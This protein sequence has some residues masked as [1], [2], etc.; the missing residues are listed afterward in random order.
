MSEPSKLTKP[1]I[2]LLLGSLLMGI[3]FDYL[4]YHK[5]VG[6]S[7]PIFWIVFS[8]FFYLIFRDKLKIEKKFE[9]FLI[10]P[11]LL[12]ILTFFFYS[13]KD[14]YV[15]NAILVTIIFI[16]QTILLTKN[17]KNPWFKLSFY[18]ESFNKTMESM[19]NILVPFKIIG[20]LVRSKSNKTAYGVLGK[21]IIGI[22][23]SLPLIGVI[24]SLLTSADSIFS[25]WVNKIPNFL[26]QLDLGDIPFQISLVLVVFFA[27]FTYLWS[28]KYP[29]DEIALPATVEQEKKPFRIDGIITLTILFLVNVVY[30]LFTSIQVS[31]LFGAA[32]RLIPEGVTY[33]EYATQ[34]FYQLV[35][36]TVLNIFIVIVVIYLVQKAQ[37]VIY[38]VV[39]ILLSLLTGCTAFILISAFQKLS[40][41]EEVYGYTYTRILVHAFMIL[42]LLLFVVALFK[43]WKND[44]SL[45]QMYIIIFLL[46][47]VALNYIN[48]D[49]I[50]AE[51]N[52]E[53]YYQTKQKGKPK[54]AVTS[55]DRYD[56]YNEYVDISYLHQLSYDVV[57]QLITLRKEPHLKP[58]I[59]E[60]LKM[61]KKEL[62]QET[63]WQSFNLSKYRAKKMI[64]NIK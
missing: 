13:S 63:D 12:L 41:Y 54:P 55:T 16:V 9:W 60:K 26:G 50:I 17:N 40:L 46:W 45:M 1:N 38:R 57:P 4:F 32:K 2:T 24:I 49:H 35:T 42:L 19:V 36:V 3:L 39:Q 29:F 21:V 22:L 30:M 62:D 15:L 7:F 31:Y 28:L 11:N 14:F 34:G 20:E 48:I 64:E 37:P 52:V 10:L 5:T 44:I 23:F 61:M 59:E 25:Y 47:Y 43:T 53:R 18:G 33:A 56:E 8:I 27:I 6:I 51:Q 58:I